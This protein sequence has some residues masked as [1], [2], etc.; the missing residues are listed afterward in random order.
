MNK[1]TH[2]LGFVQQLFD[3][4][5]AVHKAKEIIEG[6]LEAHSPR[7]SDIAREMSGKEDANYKVINVFWHTIPHSKHYYVCSKKM[8]LS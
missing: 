8:P 3:D 2:L 4:R 6:I 5:D 7:L 1:F